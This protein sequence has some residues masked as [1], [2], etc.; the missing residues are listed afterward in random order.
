MA[1]AFIDTSALVKYYHPEEG[2]Q[3]VTQII[4]EPVS[5]HYISRLSLVEAISAF[6]GK[7]RLGHIDE[8]GFADLRR[9]FYRVL[10]VFG[11]AFFAGGLG[12]TVP[13]LGLFLASAF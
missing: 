2:T 6:A 7:F 9:R 12:P 1:K 4:E 3:E 11:D 5:R 13:P 8:Q 10:R